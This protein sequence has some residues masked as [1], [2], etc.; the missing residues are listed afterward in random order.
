MSKEGIDSTRAGTPVSSCL[1]P[2]VSFSFYF[3]QKYWL[4]DISA[5]ENIEFSTAILRQITA[6]DFFQ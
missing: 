3:A 6:F 2:V 4:S 5:L 1:I